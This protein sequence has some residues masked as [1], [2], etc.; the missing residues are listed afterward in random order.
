MC[1]A[2]IWTTDDALTPSHSH[3]QVHRGARQGRGVLSHT[4][5]LSQRVNNIV[6]GSCMRCVWVVKLYNNVH[7]N[8]IHHPNTKN[9]GLEA[10][11]GL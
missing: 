8:Y 10:I 6:H 11:G 5:L 2:Q 9:R 4:E 1:P 7:T 3:H